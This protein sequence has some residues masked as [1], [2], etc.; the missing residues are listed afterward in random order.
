MLIKIQPD[1]QKFSCNA[2]GSCCSHI[3]G[4][5]PRE[6]K[7]FLKENAFGKMPV[8]QLVPVE[9]MTFPL[10]DWE[11]KRFMEWQNEANIDARIRPL[12]AIM[13]LNSGKAIILTYFMDG[14]EDSCP[15]LKN[16]KCSIY[17][18]K[19]AYVCRLFP[20][21]RSPFTNEKADENFGLSSMFGECGAM[22]HI[23]PRI[24][25]DFD[26]MIKFLNG[27]FPDGS[28]INAVQNELVIEWANKAIIRLMREKT[29]KPAMNYPYKF[30]LK[31]IENSQKIDFCDFLVESGY[32]NERE[33][34]DLIKRFDANLDAEERIK[35]KDF[36]IKNYFP[37]SR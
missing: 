37:L 13:D 7:E 16:N 36:S 19:R 28:F 1:T 8:V 24:P 29:I 11:A 35:D 5:V 6:E 22:E 30:L 27:A 26:K 20:F 15:F 4:I 9:Q 31:R 33:K 18:T 10:W 34:E 25:K 3:R 17:Q 21:N 32:L 12:R 2:C 14:K 23:I